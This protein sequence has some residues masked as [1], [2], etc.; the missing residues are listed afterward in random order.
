M[1]FME[2]ASKRYSCRA[3]RPDMV[4]DDKLDI[5][6]ECARL[7]PTAANRQEFRVIVMRTAGR[8]QDLR[9]IYGREWFSQA[10][11]VLGVCSLPSRCWSRGDGKAY[12][13]VDAA[14]VIDHM[15]LGAAA[16]GLGTCWVA[17][18]DPVA[19]REVLRL[20]PDW[21]PVVFTPLGYP[22]PGLPAKKRKGRDE[23][24]VYR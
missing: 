1:D 9:R 8:E 23:I 12:S 22:R 5:I 24:V 17:N 6:L 7:A 21:E 4:E 11:Y 15:V 10:P 14:I 18:F 19:A 20:E 13:D 2:L 3:Y 16:L